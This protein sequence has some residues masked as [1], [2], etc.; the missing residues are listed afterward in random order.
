MLKLLSAVNSQHKVQFCVRNDFRNQYVDD[1]TKEQLKK[2]N[3][4]SDII[5]EDI[6]EYMPNNLTNSIR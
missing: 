1:Y 4:D 5:H 6:L 2:A 3:E